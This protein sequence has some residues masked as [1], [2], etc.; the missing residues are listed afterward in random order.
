MPVKSPL[1]PLPPFN[2]E[3]Y[4]K[5]TAYCE[6]EK[7]KIKAIIPPPLEYVSSVFEVSVIDVVKISGLRPYKEAA[8]V[9]PVKYKNVRGG[10]VAYE[11]TTTDDAL[12]S[13]REIWGYPKKLVEEV[14]LSKHGDRVSGAAWRNGHRIISI[15][16]KI[17][18]KKIA[19][20]KLQPRLQLK[21]IPRGD[22]AGEEMKKIIQV[23][24]AGYQPLE[25]TSIKT[26]EATV[27]FEPSEDDPIYRLMPVKVLGG[28]FATGSFVLD[29]GE[30]I[31]NL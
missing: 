6:A 4:V 11:Y 16:L 21:V 7:D 17:G 14:K 1:Y 19:M 24:F 26:G 3:K 13:G 29:Y 28:V 27:S 25:A 12:C 22:K 9:V 15:N 8:L 20:P 23:H 30:E 5:L 10:H 18:P 2:F 31:A